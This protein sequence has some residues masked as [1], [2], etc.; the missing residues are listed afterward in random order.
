MPLVA[1]AILYRIYY[2]YYVVCCMANAYT[3][4]TFCLSIDIVGHFLCVH[5]F[6]YIFVIRHLTE[7]KSLMHMHM[8]VEAFHVDA[9]QSTF[10][11]LMNANVIENIT[12][13]ISSRSL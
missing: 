1:R 2:F 6:G 4:Y 9:M 11:P 3:A 5:E 8:M 12:P 10:V 7:T 13:I